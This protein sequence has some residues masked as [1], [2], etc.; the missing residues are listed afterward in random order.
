MFSHIRIR[1][2][3]YFEA[4]R[5]KNGRQDDLQGRKISIFSS[6]FSEL[7]LDIVTTFYDSKVLKTSQT[8]INTFL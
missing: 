8:I 6:F 5:I 7:G 2:I 1:Y 4:E 3:R